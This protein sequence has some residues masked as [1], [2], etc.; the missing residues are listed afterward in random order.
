MKE[1]TLRYPAKCRDCGA[2]L[3]KGTRARWYGKGKVYGNTCHELTGSHKTGGLY[4]RRTSN[5][6]SPG[7]TA[8]R[9]DPTGFYTAGGTLLG[10]TNAN[11]RCEDAPCCGCCT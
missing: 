10:R 9:Y 3:K 6:E 11:G 1:I 7:M 8:S 4:P 2:Q 5:H